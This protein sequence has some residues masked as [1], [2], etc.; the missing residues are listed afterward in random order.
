MGRFADTP[1]GEVRAWRPCAVTRAIED[2]DTDEDDR[3]AILD[4]LASPRGHREIAAWFDAAGWPLSRQT[5]QGHRD[6]DCCGGTG[7][8]DWKKSDG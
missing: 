3:E 7:K 2:D 1:R 4:M 8:V 6:G 5:V